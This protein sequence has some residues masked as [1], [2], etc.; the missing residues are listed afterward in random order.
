MEECK[1]IPTLRAFLDSGFTYILPAPGGSLKDGGMST[2]CDADL[3]LASLAS[4]AK[5][6]KGDKRSPLEYLQMHHEIVFR[7]RLF[8]A[9]TDAKILDRVGGWIRELAS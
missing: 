1:P 3:Y 8:D 2:D 5:K 7:S 9:T 6:R 4:K